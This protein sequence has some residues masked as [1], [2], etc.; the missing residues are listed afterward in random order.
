[1]NLS[2][3]QLTTLLQWNIARSKRCPAT[4][5]ASLWGCLNYQRGRWAHR[6]MR[7]D[8]DCREA[9]GV[10][11]R[12]LG[13]EA[14]EVLFGRP[15]LTLDRTSLAEIM[16]T[17]FW[18]NVLLPLDQ[19][20]E[21]PTLFD[22]EFYL[23]QPGLDLQGLAPLAHYV[24]RGAAEGRDPHPLFNTAWYLTSN[25]DVVASGVNPLWHFV[26]IG[27][28]AGRPPHRGVGGSW[29]RLAYEDVRRDRA[30]ASVEPVPITSRR[31]DVREIAGAGAAAARPPA[32][33]RPVICVSHVFPSQPRAG[34]EYRIAR[35]L[36]WLGSR[37][38]ELIVV[39]A[40]QEGAEPDD[41]IRQVF[42]EKYPNALICGRDGT[43]LVSGGM[44]ARSVA[45]LHG[46][47][48]GDVIGSHAAS[49]AEGPLTLLE[50]SLCHDGLVGV[51]AAVAR[52]YPQ[53]IYYI[54]YA[55]MTRFLRYLSCA[56]ASF[57]DTHDVLSDKSEKVRAF[58]VSDNV[59]ISAEE[60]GAMLER[61]GAV[62][63]IQPDDAARLATLAPRMPILTAAVDFAAPDVGLPPEQ[64]RI[65]VVAHDNPMNVKGV[66]DFLRF[67]WP[68]IKTARPDA[69]F[70]LVGGVAR[71][72]QYPDPRVHFAGVVDDLAACYRDARVVIN[73]SVAGTG[74]KVKTVESIAYLRPIVTF[75]S[76]VEGIQGPLL[77]LCHVA[78]D[79]YE[80][81]QKVIAL[82]DTAGDARLDG[83]R[84]LIRS[85]LE[86]GAIYAELDRWLSMS[87]QAAAA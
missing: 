62:L 70:V 16:R 54:N 43:V 33:K 67:A 73:P 11:W 49:K 61:A 68:S 51:L 34:N 22:R 84:Q 57:V 64:P 8:P 85:L 25:P 41:A 80:F 2:S 40:P 35:L 46:R 19:A 26:E 7:L 79:W 28:P 75:P 10:L 32:T 53:T 12:Q 3:D 87:D 13:R 15:L 71:A 14:V 42:F 48:I 36:D 23:K 44:L 52:L 59:V 21:V 86:P 18:R 27:G 9:L 5:G 77:E 50:S 31:Y 37:G 24:M 69:E 30:D 72:I 38:H 58:G 17:R 66:Q 78:A 39:V 60:E 82:L 1:V 45:G 65:L 20:A 83:K 47:R 4:D 76:G 6:L 55:F 63:A 29:Y 74:L 81:A 56:P